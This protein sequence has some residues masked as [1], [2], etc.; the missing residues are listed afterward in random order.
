M[1]KYLFILAAFLCA[2]GPKTTDIILP[3]GFTVKAE[4]AVTP[5]ET[6]KGLMFRTELPEGAGM[7]FVFDSDEPRYFWMKN[8]LIDLDI[9]F[10]TSDLKV[11]SYEANVPHSYVYTPDNQ[12]ATVGGFGQYVLELPAGS[13]KKH[14]IK[15][16]SSLEFYLK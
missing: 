6:E 5:E 16:G 9:I 2:C 1:K 11:F 13:V 10:I 12:V 7:L 14:D 3:D 4:L 15:E 8:T